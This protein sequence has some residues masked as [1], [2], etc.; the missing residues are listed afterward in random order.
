MYKLRQQSTVPLLPQKPLY[1]PF[2]TS[3]PCQIAAVAAAAAASQWSGASHLWTQ[4][5]QHQ[6]ELPKGHHSPTADQPSTLSATCSKQCGTASPIER[7]G[8]QLTKSPHRH[9][10]GMCAAQGAVHQQRPRQPKGQQRT[11]YCFPERNYCFPGL[12]WQAQ[13][14]RMQHSTHGASGAAQCQVVPAHAV[15]STLPARTT[16]G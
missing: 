12:L 7:A 3:Q 2:A 9:R 5:P 14:Q 15:Q 4:A 10:G 13:C 8:P 1:K 11:N 6:L 16:P